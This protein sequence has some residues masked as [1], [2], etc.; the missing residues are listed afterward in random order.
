MP[1][2]LG[3][4]R[5]PLGVP[6]RRS[7]SSSRRLWLGKCVAEPGRGL[8]WVRAVARLISLLIGISTAMRVPWQEHLV[9]ARPPASLAAPRASPRAC[10][11]QKTPVPGAGE[12]LSWQWGALRAGDPAATPAPPHRYG[13]L[14]F[15]AGSLAFLLLFCLE[16]WLGRAVVLLPWEAPHGEGQR[17]VTAGPCQ[18]ERGALRKAK[19]ISWE[20]N[21]RLQGTCQKLAGARREH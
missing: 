17:W 2:G 4:P 15:S 11:E 9:A 14:I 13:W 3:S 20:R 1:P 10:R 12:A 18:E 8:L 21:S 7:S 16:Q 5:T 19:S 6:R